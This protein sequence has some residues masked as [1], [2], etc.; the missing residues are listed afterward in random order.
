MSFTQNFNE[1]MKINLN[2]QKQI[3]IID[4][5]LEKNIIQNNIDYVSKRYQDFID[6]YLKYDFTKFK[7]KY[8]LYQ[9]SSDVIQDLKMYFIDSIKK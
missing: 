4:S 1:Q 8:I 2:F 9:S 3:K 7:N 5:T 6:K